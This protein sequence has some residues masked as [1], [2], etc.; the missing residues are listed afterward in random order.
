MHTQ[1]LV[2]L[3]LSE[4]SGGHPCFDS[5]GEMHALS[6]CLASCLCLAGSVV[7]QQRCT[8]LGNAIP[9]L[10]AEMGSC[11]VRMSCTSRSRPEVPPGPAH[12]LSESGAPWLLLGLLPAC[13]CMD[14]HHACGLFNS[15]AEHRS[16]KRLCI[17][18]TQ[19]CSCIVHSSSVSA[20]CSMAQRPLCRCTA[21]LQ[22]Q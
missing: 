13:A 12:A 7:C 4:T 8:G 22:L 10:S 19:S 20:C 15:P 18:C 1:L 21:S 16:L 3:G 11:L 2:V 17:S 6:S 9:L 5:I 14:P